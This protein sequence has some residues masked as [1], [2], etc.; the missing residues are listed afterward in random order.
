MQVKQLHIM[1]TQYEKPPLQSTYKMYLSSYAESWEFICRIMVTQE[2]TSLQIY[3]GYIL[4]CY[5]Y[6]SS[7]PV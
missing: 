4:S 3:H 1:K 5:D 6:I 2:E 7:N